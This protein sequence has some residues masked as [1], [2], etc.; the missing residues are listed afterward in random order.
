[1]YWGGACFWE[2]ATPPPQGGGVPALP[3]IWGF[4]LFLHTPLDAKLP[5]LTLVHVETG[6][7]VRRSVTPPPTPR[8]LGLR[9]P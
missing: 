7:V 3:N 4:L 6:F 8:W 1:M 2:S 5:N 9:A